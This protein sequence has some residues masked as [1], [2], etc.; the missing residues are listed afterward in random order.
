MGDHAVDRQGSL[1]CP[2]IVG[3]RYA[4]VALAIMGCAAAF[5]GS[6][7]AAQEPRSSWRSPRPPCARTGKSPGERGGGCAPADTA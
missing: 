1:G 7:S 4:V 3:W 6:R 2:L 5:R